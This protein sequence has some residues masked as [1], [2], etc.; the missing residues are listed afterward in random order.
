MENSLNC[1][2]PDSLKSEGQSAAKP[3][4]GRSETIMGAS[5]PSLRKLERDDGIVRT[6]K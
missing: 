6:W 3:L 4:G 2:K 5:L 1:W